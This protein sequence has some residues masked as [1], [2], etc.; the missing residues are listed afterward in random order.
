MGSSKDG[1]FYLGKLFD[2]GQ[3]KLLDDPILLIRLT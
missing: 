2:L 1:N 3:K